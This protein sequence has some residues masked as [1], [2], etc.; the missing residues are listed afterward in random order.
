M[1][2]YDHQLMARIKLTLLWVLTLSA[3]AAEGPA[4]TVAR[5]D[6]AGITIVESSSA[7]WSETPDWTVD[8]QPFL[9]LATSGEGEA[10][11]F[12]GVT[13]ALRLQDGSIAVA[14]GRVGEIR[15]F[16]SAGE[17]L[18]TVG[19]R[20][21]GPG[22]F[23]RLVALEPFAGDS[24]LAFDAAS[25]RVTVVSP[26]WEIARLISFQPEVPSVIRPLGD[27]TIIS[28]VR[29]LGAESVIRD[30]H[31]R[32][33]QPVVR[34]SSRGRVIDTVTTT[35]GGEIVMLEAGAV[36][37]RALF[38]K[39]SYLATRSGRFVLGSADAMEYNVFGADARIEQIV[40]VPGYDL[41]L[42]ETEVA[43]SRP[44]ARF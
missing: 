31:A 9:D 26:Q 3:C 12:F 11:E 27:S 7:A 8:P 39:S 40:R 5:R 37:A 18:K 24:I 35:L 15:F 2:A 38:G 6:S 30:G 29:S 41:R 36:D 17:F 1:A 32:Q 16:S 10:H 44:V 20:G 34:F 19:S 25:Q 14:L 22:E 28:L 4:S 21:D 42:S 33:P 13:D 23:R 43:G